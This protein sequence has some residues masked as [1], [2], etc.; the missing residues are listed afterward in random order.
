MVSVSQQVRAISD[1]GDRTVITIEEFARLLGI[2]RSAAYEAA[3]RD[4][5]P[6]RRLGRR[7]F[8]PVPALRRWLGAEGDEPRVGAERVGR[9]RSNTEESLP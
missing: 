7:L 1:L 9:S 4:E 3:S 5:F 6:I 8:V 2:S